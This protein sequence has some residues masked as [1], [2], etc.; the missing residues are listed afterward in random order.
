MPTA[1]GF[2]T[3]GNPPGSVP[4]T[5]AQQGIWFGQ[6]L[7]ASARYHVAAGFEV[8]GNLDEVLFERAFRAVLA[9]AEPLR[10]R[11]T[12]AEGERPRQRVEPLPSWAPE[13]VDLR[14][15]MFPLAAAV[16]WLR[17]DVARPFDPATG[18]LFRT[19]FIRLSD[20]RVCWSLVCHHLVMDGL[21]GALFARRLGDIYGALERG[22]EPGHGA[23]VSLDALLR[24]ESDYRA[25][26]EFAADRA[27]WLA[28]MAGRPEPA[29]PRPAGPTADPG[30]GSGVAARGVARLTGTGFATLRDLARACE[31]RWPVVV[32]T[33]GALMA[34]A[35]SGGAGDEV[36]V[37]L[38]VAGRTGPLARAVAGM[39]SNVLP[40]RIRIHPDRPATDLIRAVGAE[41]SAALAHQ[42]YPQE[43]L[44]RD[45]G[46]AATGRGLHG[47][48][49]NVMPFSFGKRFAGRPMTMHHIAV[50]P[51]DDLS[52]TVHPEA[53]RSGL[54]VDLY[55]SS[56]AYGARA[57]G[58]EARRFARLL[59]GLTTRAEQPV[60]RLDLLSAAE[61]RWALPRPPTPTGR[62]ASAAAPVAG[63]LPG[64]VERWAARTPQAPAVGCGQERLSY[65]ELN[66]R[67][68]RLARHLIGLGAG[69]ERTVAVV[70]PRSVD[71]VVA[72]LAVTKTGAAY[73]PADPAWPADR[74]AAILADARPVHVITPTELDAVPART[75]TG[76]PTDLDRDL[77]DADRPGPLTPDCAAY[78][79]YTSGSTG[80]PK[81][82]VVPHRGPVSLLT[83]AA[84]DFG[85]DSRDV[86]TMFHSSAFD[87]SV[88]EMWGALAHGGRLVVVPQGV[89]RSPREMLDLLDRERVTV[90]NQTPSAFHAL[91]RADAEA[92]GRWRLPALRR[93][94][95][96][97]E[98]LR[99]ARLRAWCERRGPTSTAVVNMYGI[100]ETTVHATRL[101]LTAGHLADSGS[102]MGTPLPGTRLHVLD[103]RLRPVPPGVVG[104]LYVAGAGV[105]RGYLGRPDLTAQ[106]FV[107]DPFGPPGSRLYRSGDLVRWRYDGSLEYV[108]RADDQV[109]IRG[110]RIEPAE[111]ESALLAIPGVA[112]AAVTA[113]PTVRDDTDTDTDGRAGTDG[114]GTPGAEPRL[115]AHVLPAHPAEA[116]HGPD[117]DPDHGADD[118][119]DRFLARLRDALRTRLPEHMIPALLV[120]VSELPL[121]PN[122]KLD[123]AALPSPVP[124]TAQRSDP[125]R[126]RLEQRVAA[127]YTDLLGASDVGS[128]DSFFALGGDSLSAARLVGAV[129][130]TLGA[131]LDVRDV[132]EHPTVA[133]LAARLD[134]PDRYGPDRYGPDPDHP[135]EPDARTLTGGAR[136]ER[137][138]LSFGQR[139]L[140]LLHSL[141]G[142]G[143]AYNVPLV[144]RLTGHVDQEALRA[145]LADLAGRHEALR[146]VV[147]E[148]DGRP[149]QW[150]L[151][152]AEARPEL[153][154]TRT[155]PARLPDALAAR[156]RH[157][158]RLDQEPPL[159]ADLFTVGPTEHTLLVLLHHIACDHASLAPLL[160]DLRTAYAARLDGRAPGWATPPAQYADFTLRQCELL[161]TDDHPTDIARRGIAHWT[162]VLDGLPERIQLPADRTPRPG[163]GGDTVGFRIP[164]ALH[165]RLAGLAAEERA[166]LF[167]VVH[168]GLAALLT[169]LGAGTDIPVGTAVSE[170][171]DPLF[172]DTVGFLV[173]TLLL[174][175]DTS[176]EVT[177]RE[178]LG[179]VR[180]TDLTA[181]AHQEVPFDLVM[182]FLRPR[183]A[184]SG[185][186]PFQVMLGVTPA[187]PRF[188][189]PGATA[190][191]GTVGTGAAKFDLSFSLYEH[192]AADGS[193]LGLDGVLEYR[194]GLLGR[195]TAEAICD[196]FTRLLERVA[197]DPDTPVHRVDL[198]S[199]AERR[200]L[201][202]TWAAPCAPPRG[203]HATVPGR[204]AEQVRRCPD[205]PAVRAGGQVLTYADL[206]ARSDRLAGRLTA[207]GV[208]AET[209]V[210]VLLD[211]GADHVVTVLAILK[212]GGVYLPLDSRAPRSRQDAVLAEARAAVLVTDAA[213]PPGGPGIVDV[214]D[215]RP[216]P[217]PAVTTPVPG[218]VD[219]P[220]ALAYVT[221]TSGSTGTPKGVAVTHG[222]V[223]ALALDSCWQGTRPQRVL[224][225]SPHSFDAST[226]ELWVPLLNGGEIVVAPPGDLDLATLGRLLTGT[227]VTTLW[228]TAGLFQLVAEENPGCLRE[229]DTVWTGGDVVSPRAVSVVRRHCPSTRVVNGYGPSEATTFA[230]RHLVTDTGRTDGTDR[231]DSAAVPIGRPL[232]GARAYVLDAYL[233]LV[234]PGV[235]GDLYLGGTGIARGYLHRPDLTAER[236]V[237]DPFGPPGARMYRTG[238]LARRQPDGVLVFAGRTDGQVKLRGFRIETD[239]VATALTG[240]GAVGQAAV[241]VRED[242]PGERRLVAYL[243]P[244]RGRTVDEAAVRDHAAAVLPDYMVPTAY[245]VVDHLPLTRNHKI[246][247]AALPAP[248]MAAPH[249]AAPRTAHER[250]L[251]EI[252]AQLLG[253]TAI[254]VDDGFFTLGGDSIMAIQ[255]VSR[256]HEAGVRISVRDVFRCATMAEL[257]RTAEAAGTAQEASA[258]TGAEDAA[259]A[260]PPT[261]VMH[262]WREQ[263]RGDL[264]AFSQSVT[265]RT[266][267]GLTEETLTASVQALL[268]HHPALRLRLTLGTASAPREPAEWTLDVLPPGDCRAGDRVRRVDATDTWDRLPRLL[269]DAGATARDRLDPT[270]GAMLFAVFLDAGPGA[271]GRLVLVVHHLAV[272]GVSWRILLPDL[273]AAYQ[274]VTAG[275]DPELPSAPTSFRKWA[276]FLAEQGRTGARR[277]ELPLWRET[278]AAAR[279]LTDVPHDAAG[280]AARHLTLTLPPERTRPLLTEVGAAF[281]CGVEP[282]LLTALG[283]ALTE[284]RRRGRATAA[285]AGAA[286]EAPVIE[287]ES[288]GRPDLPGQDLSRTVGWFTSVFPFP[289]ETAGCDWSQVR[290]HDPALDR[291]LKETK[292]RLRAVPDRGIGY[293]VLRH[294]DE[295]TAPEL[296]ALGQ[297]QIGFNYLGRLAAQSQTDWGLVP[298]STTVPETAAAAVAPPTP[299]ADPA[300]SP[301]G[302][303]LIALDALT[304]DGPSG[305]RLHATWTWA[306][307]AFTE[308]DTRELAALW[309]T[310]LDALVARARTAGAGGRT[311]SDLPLV[312]FGQTEIEQLEAAYPG[313]SD[314]LP[315]TPLQ[316]GLHFHSLYAPDAPDVYHA[317]FV[318]HLRG[319]LDR[320]VL[321]RAVAALL[322]RH[323]NLR[324]AFVHQG[325]PHPVQVLPGPVGPEWRDIDLTPVA[326]PRR[327]R[328]LRRITHADLHRRFDLER[329]PLLRFTLVTWGPDEYRLVLTNHHLVLD[330]WSMPLFI[331]ELLAL[332]A[333]E[334]DRAALPPVTPYR[335]HLHALTALDLAAARSAWSA[336]LAGADT[337]PAFPTTPRTTA[338]AQ[339][340]R[341]DVSAD[342]TRRLRATSAGGPTLNTVVQAAWAL[343]LAR[344][345]G[346]RDIV[347]GTTVSGRQPHL[348]GMESMIGLFINTVPVR[349]GID[350]GETVRDL[351]RRF[352]DEQAALLPHQH[353]GLPDIQRLTGRRDLFDTHL[354]FENYPLERAGLSQDARGL[355]LVH[356]EGQD[357][358]H[359]P[360]S[361]A[362]FADDTRLSLRLT[363]RPDVVEPSRAEWFARELRRL[364]RALAADPGARVTDLLGPPAGTTA[365]SDSLK[366]TS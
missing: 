78:V 330:G 331:R 155:D 251:C 311:P 300:S 99:P 138:P 128:G 112:G 178:L 217:D 168:A 150:I 8:A 210:G 142:P 55:A 148:A 25:G 288:H 149:E 272:D 116:D 338:P 248:P 36:V 101:D 261:P 83:G 51:V 72:I 127:L 278:L 22:E 179:R 182:E 297:P 365:L 61:R 221:Y 94:I 95:F 132:F 212:C 337:A 14:H 93:V 230:T 45:L 100:T 124:R 43:D 5:T 346:R 231:E 274:A 10:V 222:D 211:R 187:P 207:H 219:H 68:N 345:G 109:K 50:G 129:R 227:G 286:T 336:A 30:T 27:F 295:R 235:T 253:V 256:A 16:E 342:L 144:L 349:V 220:D 360:L 257:A 158:F 246:D 208:T 364:L 4:L 1:G 76:E 62:R 299:E 236:F 118:A 110:F 359:Y 203:E 347:F 268:D 263:Q 73:L 114:G 6:K 237:A 184:A 131:E 366:G 332:Y 31:V 21:G 333:E 69:P 23:G 47:F 249:R 285:D 71:L 308:T 123:R 172:D 279:P 175:T 292:E 321:R 362:A 91:D 154:V 37:G 234:P 324:A 317:Q 225:H 327:E 190:T 65:A 169:R 87:F 18:P 171:G 40:L 339:S 59:S 122:G 250:L 63:T 174:R 340:L 206:D 188:E 273:A 176:G 9:E 200:R 152:P 107:A 270:T 343:L 165:A 213:G 264:A 267:P 170:R 320:D 303:H 117:H 33:A 52:V 275:R 319:D 309:T 192:R 290:A 323:P 260:L 162:E 202:T 301:T 157:T 2:G 133:A 294:L 356:V 201:L 318:L 355:R 146:T 277:D 38:P 82:V 159:R 120:P 58:A 103:S 74:I 24:A 151:P 147:R 328:V 244:E 77:T 185:Q 136:P 310:A 284:W 34:H 223:L 314:V 195:D 298:E 53:Q 89:H 32:V 329:P 41:L 130:R 180:Q 280:S 29:A 119:T 102:P 204:F 135:A 344:R 216:V 302:H 255:L 335:E 361:L 239:E 215:R 353:L 194:T 281:H 271:P 357:A 315:L 64:L 181:F 228:L 226:M 141:D 92:P 26:P 262:W 293:G 134:R 60:G 352:Q 173:N 79:I 229:L 161:G 156:A 160:A 145:A 84:A 348:R 106:R 325:L 67:A 247:R 48:A 186:A 57:A 44:G 111:I 167:M 305:P 177:F 287:L 265:V 98:A 354:V 282:V 252:A 283:L 358:T 238:D 19:A 197:T 276:R 266:P 121:T 306:D 70:L 90:L 189:L 20:H 199:S 269:A 296:R 81:G 66:A 193:G 209:P 75:A 137:V 214:R 242:R 245:V 341:V 334:G 224:L 183:R 54:R 97:G 313:L 316:Q 15:E 258:A 104:E 35:R 241:V 240:H 108:A 115:V 291:A 363:Y 80:R 307:K 28:R 326:A 13:F 96:G 312:R 7:A 12:E 205:A 49:V 232:D 350:P 17:A 39:T 105:A 126:T 153:T 125:P 351:L 233:H 56:S 198:L 289:L 259:G 139:R 85:F 304:V 46:L 163:Q 218:P 243:V 166:S 143:S 164:A 113:W 86:W 3:G 196:R 191:V 88:W 322:D 11:F 42:R 254:G 140:W